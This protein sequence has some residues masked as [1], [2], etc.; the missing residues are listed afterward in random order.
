MKRRTKM[1]VK[2]Y[3]PVAYI[4][5]KDE[6]YVYLDQREDGVNIKVRGSSSGHILLLG[7][8]GVIHRYKHVNENIGFIL[9]DDGRVLGGEDY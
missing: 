6:I 8:D 2:I 4:P 5:K 9:D 7:D 3:N 1:K